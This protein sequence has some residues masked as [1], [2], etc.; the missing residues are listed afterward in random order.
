MV[1]DAY[2]LKSV[3]GRGTDNPVGLV[4]IFH[5]VDAHDK[6]IMNHSEL[7]GG[8]RRLIETGKIVECSQHLFC[9]AKYGEPNFCFPASLSQNIMKHLKNMKSGSMKNIALLINRV[10]HNPTL[11]RDCAKARSPLAPR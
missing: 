1:F 5:Y 8:L 2:I 6:T 10:P 9:D 3:L 4:E 7:E 11:K